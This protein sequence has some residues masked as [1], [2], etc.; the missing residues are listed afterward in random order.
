MTTVRQPARFIEHRGTR[1]L[2][3]DFVG[4]TD[5]QEGLGAVE[6]ARQF[7]AR[8]KQ[9]GSLRIC[10]DVTDTRYDRQIVDA[11]KRFTA[12]NKPFVKHS[13]IVSNSGMHRAAISMIAIVSRRKLHVVETRDA[14]LDWLAE[15]P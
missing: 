8:Q 5:V 2:L 12:H 9:D 14:A 4:I 15:Q 13:A 6:N 1:I 7:I 10:T 3:L 11:F